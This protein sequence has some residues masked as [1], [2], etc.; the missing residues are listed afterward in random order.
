[1]IQS[2]KD[3]SLCKQ[4]TITNLTGAVSRRDSRLNQVYATG[5]MGV[6]VRLM[7]GCDGRSLGGLLV[8]EKLIS[9]VLPGLFMS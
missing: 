9:G 8:T 3:D 4:S 6:R 2:N 5:W 1:M 7:A